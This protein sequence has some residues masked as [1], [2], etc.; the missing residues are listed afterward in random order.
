M[1]VTEHVSLSILDGAQS[2][3]L[4]ALTDEEVLK[5]LLSPECSID[6]VIKSTTE[7]PHLSRQQQ[8]ES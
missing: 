6:T 2:Q 4:A 3:G 1:N 5:C 8:G 7:R